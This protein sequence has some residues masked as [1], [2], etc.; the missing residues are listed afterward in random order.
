MAKKTAQRTLNLAAYNEFVGRFQ[1]ETDRAAAVLG[2]SYLDS[3]L[4]SALRSVLVTGARVDAMFDGPGAPL[5]SFSNKTAVA[6][7]LGLIE[8]PMARDIDLVR[9]VRNHFAHQIWDATF[10][11]PPV[12]GW[13]QSLGLVSSLRSEAGDPVELS[14]P[15]VRYL[16][17]IALTTTRIAYSP[18]VPVAFRKLIIGF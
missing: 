5:G 10:D 11:S 8:E 13:C 3:F 4:E 17:T 12:S 7:A 1:A 16:L 2:G 14:E 15:R 6:F 9:K 18:K